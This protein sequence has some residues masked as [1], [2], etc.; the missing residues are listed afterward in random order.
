MRVA[1]MS[2]YTEGTI[3]QDGAEGRGTVFI[4]KPFERDV[5]KRKVR[6]ALDRA[7]EKKAR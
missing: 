1:F 2:G 5:L 3:L 7:D 6:E 4:A